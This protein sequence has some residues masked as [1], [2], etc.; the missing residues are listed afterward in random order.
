MNAVAAVLNVSCYFI[1]P[2]VCTVIFI[3]STLWN[4]A[5]PVNRVYN[6]VKKR[7]ILFIKRAINKNKVV[8]VYLY[9][10]HVTASKLIRRCPFYDGTFLFVGFF[11]GLIVRRP[12]LYACLTAS[13][14]C[15]RVTEAGRS[16][17]SIFTLCFMQRIYHFLLLV[18]TFFSHIRHKK[19]LSSARQPVIRDQG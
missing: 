16:V 2:E 5:A 15:S 12:S 17:I 4:K 3:Q 13:R 18:P 14:T 1:Q 11:F 9:Y 8:I 19:R 6:C 7:S 10:C